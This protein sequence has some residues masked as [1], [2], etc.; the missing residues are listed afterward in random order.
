MIEDVGE[1]TDL[2]GRCRKVYGQITF[3]DLGG[4]LRQSLQWTHDQE[5][6]SVG[7]RGDTQKQYGNNAQG[8]VSEPSNLVISRFSGNLSQHSP[9]YSRDGLQTTEHVYSSDA[10]I[11]DD[12]PFLL[13]QTLKNRPPECDLHEVAGVHLGAHDEVPCRPYEICA[14]GFTGSERSQTFF[15]SPQVQPG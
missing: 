10:F 8:H 14:T 1:V 15:G 11:G 12:R 9:A 2:P 5:S 3:G 13:Q 4:P 7:N 6:E